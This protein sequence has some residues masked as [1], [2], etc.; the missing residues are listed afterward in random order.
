MFLI[1]IFISLIILGVYITLWIVARKHPDS[2]IGKFFSRLQ[3]AMEEHYIRKRDEK[4]KIRADWEKRK[5]QKKEFKAKHPW[6]CMFKNL[7]IFILVVGLVFGLPVFAYKKIALDYTG[8]Y[9]K[10]RFIYDSDEGLCML[11]TYYPEYRTGDEKGFALA[12]LPFNALGFP[13]KSGIDKRKG[14]DI[15]D[16]KEILDSFQTKSTWGGSGL[17]SILSLL[18]G[19]ESGSSNSF[20]IGKHGKYF[21]IDGRNLDY[22]KLSNLF[23]ESDKSHFLNNQ[24]Y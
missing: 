7:M 9:A 5:A 17:L 18:L 23:D 11:V 24:F 15:A 12:H 6:F 13:L 10:D 22:E 4:E 19:A 21:I 8:T 2:T 20:D 16:S 3:E 14:N 1:I